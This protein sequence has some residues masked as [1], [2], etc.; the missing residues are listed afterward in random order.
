MA[1]PS[2]CLWVTRGM[3]K[4]ALDP[5]RFR[6]ALL[7]ER[8]ATSSEARTLEGDLG[9]GEGVGVAAREMLLAHQH[10][11]RKRLRKEGSDTTTRGSAV[12]SSRGPHTGDSPRRRG[13]RARTAKPSTPQG[14]RGESGASCRS[15]CRGRP[16]TNA[17]RA[18]SGIGSPWGAVFATIGSAGGSP[19]TQDRAQF[20][21]STPPLPGRMCGPRCVASAARRCQ[22]TK[23]LNPTLDVLMTM[24]WGRAG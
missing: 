24:V 20:A 18:H 3:S 6:L 1:P 9:G 14:L 22:K 5:F 17:A 11:A 16:G 10:E 8:F 7:P 23:R 2:I 13:K 21:A 15:G 19:P 12:A 4:I